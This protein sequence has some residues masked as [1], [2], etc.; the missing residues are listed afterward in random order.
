M[1]R[2][3]P[4]NPKVDYQKAN[5]KLI[6]EGGFKAHLDALW[7][8]KEGDPYYYMDWDEDGFNLDEG[9]IVEVMKEDEQRY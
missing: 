4:N 6:K 5:D 3:I 7:M 8:P 1:K 2:L 9:E